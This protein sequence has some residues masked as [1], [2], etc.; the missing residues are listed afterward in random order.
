MTRISH[1]SVR[2]LHVVYSDVGRETSGRMGCKG[3]VSARMHALY[4]YRHSYLN[5]SADCKTVPAEY[6]ALAR[7][8]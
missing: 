3:S 6:I 8:G 2:S 5:I 7:S 1:E 4:T